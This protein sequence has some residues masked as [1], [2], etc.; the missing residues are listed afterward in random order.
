MRTS[1]PRTPHLP[2]SP[3]AAADDVRV[4]DLSGLAGQE[5]VVTEKL[6][7]ENTTLYP[8]GLHARSLDSAHHPSRAWVKGLHGRIAHAI[9]DSW[10]ICGENVYA[11]HSI[12]YADLA[13]WFYAFSVW[14]GEHCLDWDT[15]VRF[16]RRLGIP[17]PP[18]LWRGIFEE[19]AIRA[20][21]LDLARQEGYVVRT[22]AGFHR[23]EFAGRVAKW[24]RPAHVQTEVHWMSAPVV[25]NGLGPDAPLW[26]VR[27]GAAPDGPAL[28]A[29][30]G[31]VTGQTVA[32]AVTAKDTV[33]AKAAEDMAAAEASAR[34][35]LLGRTGDVR[36]AA[37][38]AALLHTQPRAGLAA[39]LRGPLG[40]P[41][42][43]RVA[44]LVG[45]HSK[46]YRR[47]PDEQRRPGLVRMAAAADLGVLH[48]VAA[49]ALAGP[50]GPDADDAGWVGDDADDAREQLDW[51]MLHAEDAGLL[52]P[53]PLRGLRVGLRDALTG[54]A[55]D[56]DAA[57]RCWAQ[58][59]AAYALGRIGTPEEAAAATWRWR[60]GRFPRLVVMVGPAGSGKSSFAASVSDAAPGAVRGAVS[61]PVADLVTGPVRRAAADVVVNLDEL[62]AARGSRSNQRDNREVL[63][64]GLARLD[65]ALAGGGTTIW[66]ATSLTPQQRRLVHAV[67]DRR[68]A[69]VTHA[70][71]VVGAEELARRNTAREHAVPARVLAGQ[72][73][74]FAPPYPGEAHRIWYVG[75]GGTVDDVA[76]SIEDP[77]ED[78]YAGDA[79]AGA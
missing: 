72:L 10:R 16:T 13:S 68:D 2:W 75:P 28:R 73:S 76:G 12:A 79:A 33:A 59:R 41:L 50:P 9:P 62:R 49:A 7:G 34:V 70:V 54:S 58:A 15:T 29:C 47:Y 71:L 51:S 65:T 63:R 22:V 25:V 24:V 67:A 69:L 74:R 23:A 39:W 18:T 37:V 56:P 45:L 11:R 17:V 27:S 5:V 48:A 26:Q 1:Y 36:L 44:D 14:A 38:L 46:L 61:G 21:R 20:L 32:D 60:A 31:L 77:F 3:G 66:D 53:A 43:R 19:R 35:D 42:A 52:G 8:D 4:G 57:D 40:M 6:D 30:L 55:P 64:D 78:T